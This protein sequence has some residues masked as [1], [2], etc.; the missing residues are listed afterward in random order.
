MENLIRN[1][2]D[3]VLRSCRIADETSQIANQITEDLN[4]QKESLLNT[5]KKAEQTNQDLL[6][7]QVYIRKVFLNTV[8][9]KY[10]LYGVIL[11]EIIILISLLYVKYLSKIL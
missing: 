4:C 3:S 10:I 8:T 7:S 6:K 5:Q 11:L 9:N 2:N 1:T